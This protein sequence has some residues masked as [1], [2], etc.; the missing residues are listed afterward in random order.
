MCNEGSQSRLALR[1]GNPRF[2]LEATVDA[3]GGGSGGVK[4]KNFFVAKTL[5]SESAQTRFSRVL[6]FS[7]SARR[8]CAHQ[9]SIKESPVT[10][11]FLA[12]SA[13]AKRK[14]S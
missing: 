14:D 8:I 4:H 12:F 6:L 7:Q 13:N 5:D 3:P 2:A 11:A 10:R 1:I 9:T